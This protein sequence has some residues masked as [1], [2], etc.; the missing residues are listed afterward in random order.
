MF[1]ARFR[2]HEFFVFIIGIGLSLCLLI[3]SY[4][5]SIYL[6][7][8]FLSL[9]FLCIS[10]LE[11]KSFFSVEAGVKYFILGSIAS[12]FVLFGASLIY[13]CVECLQLFRY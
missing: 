8:E 4:D 2:A 6:N 9:I 7:M 1:S 11:K 3:S 13:F 12:I 5:L 10:G